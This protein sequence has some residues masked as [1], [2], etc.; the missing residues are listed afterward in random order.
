MHHFEQ[1]EEEITDEELRMASEIGAQIASVAQSM[2]DELPE[3][4]LEEEI[5]EELSTTAA[6]PQEIGAAAE[7]HTTAETNTI[8][9]SAVESAE[10]DAVI[11]DETALDDVATPDLEPAA[12]AQSPSGSTQDASQD[13]GLQNNVV[14]IET[15]DNIN[16]EHLSNHQLALM[17]SIEN[18]VSLLTQQHTKAPSPE[19]SPQK[20]YA[21]AVHYAKHETN[22]YLAGKWFRK[23]AMQGH[24]KAQFYLGILFTKGDGV[25]KSFFHAYS[26][27]SLASCQGLDE[28]IQARKKLEPYLSARDINAALKHAAEKLEQ[29]QS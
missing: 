23:A 18:L 1:P 5:P 22:Y 3:F 6:S 17:E 15:G 8:E 29:I 4:E 7:T 28:A 26:W 20:Q 16:Q 21:T 19:Q 14:S 11:E 25:P 27:L 9:S 10:A 2:S 24:A 13:V 12:T